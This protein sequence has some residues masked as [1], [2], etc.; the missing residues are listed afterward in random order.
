MDKKN[1]TTKPTTKSTIIKNIIKWLFIIGLLVFAYYKN[2]EF[3][4]EAF[5]N[6]DDMP[7][8]II[9]VCLLLGCIYYLFEGAIISTMSSKNETRLTLWQGVVCGFLCA[10]YKLATLG[11][12]TGVAQIYYYKINGIS[13]SEATGMSIAQYTFQK[14]SIGIMGV[15]SFFVLFSMDIEGIVKYSNYMILGVLVIIIICLALFLIIVSK[16][17]AN[18]LIFIMNK[19]IKQE[20]RLYPVSQKAKENIIS[21]QNQGRIIWHDRILFIKIEIFNFMKFICWYS[22]PGI[23]I[24]NSYDVSVLVC[25]G[26]MSVCNMIGGVMLAPSSIGTLDFV[27]AL[28]FSTIVESSEYV[29]AT[30][31]MYRFFTW[32]V[33]FIIGVVPAFLV[34]KKQKEQE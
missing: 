34:R 9:V 29:I 20:S 2:K 14:I 27:F 12:A 25:I 8:W 3:V 6:I 11:S 33:P 32:M 5:S 1:T 17:I 30:L 26:L 22:V 18:L 13:V 31:I 19:I 16:K 7:I 28:L 15:V 4:G 10:F 24:L 21:L 23:I